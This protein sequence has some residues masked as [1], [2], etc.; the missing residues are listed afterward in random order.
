MFRL[1]WIG[2]VVVGGWLGCLAAPLAYGVTIERGPV[3]IHPVPPAGEALE[4]WQG[5]RAWLKAFA[6]EAPAAGPVAPVE[7]GTSDLPSFRVSVEKGGVALIRFAVPIP[8]R[9]LHEDEPL[10]VATP[11][12]RKLAPQL[13]ILSH[14]GGAVAYVRRAM[15]SFVYT[16][17]EAGSYTFHL[18]RATPDAPLDNAE[19]PLQALTL[20]VEDLG[21]RLGV[22]DE[23]HANAEFQELVRATFAGPARHFLSDT[24]FEVIENGPYYLWVRQLQACAR[25]PRILELQADAFGSTLFQVHLQQHGEGFGYAPDFAAQLRLPGLQHEDEQLHTHSFEAGPLP[26]LGVSA[27]DKGPWRLDAP[28]GAWAGSG[29][30]RYGGATAML[31]HHPAPTGANVPHQEGAWRR[32]AVVGYDSERSLVQGGVPGFGIPGTIASSYYEDL[33]FFTAAPAVDAWPELVASLDF[34]HEAMA[35]ANAKGLD[36]GNIGSMNR[37]N[38]C[39][40]IFHAYYRSGDGRLR[41]TALR[42]TAN[43]HDLSVWWDPG[44]GDTFGG[45]RYNN[46]AAMGTDFEHDP[47]F[48]WRSNSAVH[49]C[50]KGY[51]SFLYAWEE[52]GDPAYGTALRHQVAYASAYVRANE[53][54]ARNVG[55]VLDFVQLYRMTGDPSLLAS[56]LRLFR[57][58]RE[59]TGDDGLFSQSGAPIVE[60]R[61][62]IDDDAQGTLYPFPKPYILGYG[63][64]GLPALL[65]EYP[66]EERLLEIITAVARFMAASIDPAGG[67]RYPDKDSSGLMIE[68]GME[69]AAQ[70][71]RAGAALEAHGQDVDFIL[72]AIEKVLQARVGSFLASGQILSGIGG[73]ERATGLVAAGECLHDLYGGPHERDKSRDYTEGQ[74]ATGPTGQPDGLVYFTEVLACYLAHRP[75]E[76]LLNSSP[77]LST[78]LARMNGERPDILVEESTFQPFGVEADLP[79]FAEA[80]IARMDFPLAL[81]QQVPFDL[82]SARSA[83]RAALFAALEPRPPRRH[84]A[85][86][87]IAVEQRAGYEA[88]KIRFNLSADYRVNGYLLIPDGDGPFPAVLALHDHGAHFSIGKEKVVRPFD[89]ESTVLDDAVQWTDAYYGGRFIGDELAQRGYVVLAVDALYWGERGRK[90]GSTYED[91]QA[92]GANLLQ[93]GMNWLS[94]VTW[95]DIRSAELLVAQPEVDPGRVAALGLSMG[96]HRTWMLCAATDL[97]HAGAA[98]MWLGDTPAMLSPGNNQTRGQSA[99][100]MI[101]PGLRNH[102]DYTDVAALAAPKPMLFYNGTEDTLFPIPGVDRAFGILREAWERAGADEAL[103]TEWWE[104]PHLFNEAMQEKVFAWLDEK[105][106][107]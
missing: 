63:L 45:T 33:Y 89:V 23:D 29:E 52:T 66:E 19:T 7:T 90:E 35:K 37:L 14:H 82:R 32:A 46:R 48:M 91:Q 76:R 49:F 73:W 104:A 64:A 88:R 18:L 20:R 57:E 43:F 24:R 61:P 54:E 101:A 58:L 28:Q 34:H 79:G 3:T 71:C 102:L 78:V 53:G 105:L 15:L 83:G 92:L 106:A 8:Y 62:F 80:R 31:A 22:V 36:H 42:W 6:F 26:L 11:D 59:R 16:F 70:L 60:E 107:R 47:R 10:S 41:E 12:G 72:D 39:P 5:E 44:H 98:I 77:Q 21:F 56:G 85:Q 75:A 55:D 25:Y 30:A 69:H 74:I 68:Q 103:V 94:V 100:S 93:L 97:V 4:Q 40:P 50:T 84:F 67:W 87:T 27:P 13:R 1:S 9:A 51:D 17:P 96:A 38:H 99:F 2:V 65:R 95:D 81:R 86:E